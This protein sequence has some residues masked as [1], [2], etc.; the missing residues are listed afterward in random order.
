MELVAN[1][2][3]TNS[4]ST[5]TY[6]A[7]QKVLSL[8]VSNIISVY[9]EKFDALYCSFD[10]ITNNYSV[11]D[12]YRKNCLLCTLISTVPKIFFH[13]LITKYRFTFM[14]DFVLFL[15]FNHVIYFVAGGG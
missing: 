5:S 3:G 12:F 13:I 9:V 4:L 15:Y 8:L 2:L 10:C 6:S 14:K 11:H 7:S 1:H